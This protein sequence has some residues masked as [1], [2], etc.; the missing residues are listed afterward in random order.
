MEHMS[1]LF[2]L[3]EFLALCN[4][5]SETLQYPAWSYPFPQLTKAVLLLHLCASLKTKFM[6]FPLGASTEGTGP[7]NTVDM[8]GGEGTR[9]SQLHQIKKKKHKTK[10]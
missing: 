1:K 2:N 3:V 4:L 8:A 5:E 10:F 7:W 6:R 9:V